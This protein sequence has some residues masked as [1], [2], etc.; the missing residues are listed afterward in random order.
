MQVTD[1]D[2]E[3]LEQIFFGGNGSF[4]D[5]KGER[6][7]FL[8]CFD[9]SL[10]VQACPGSGKT[11]T[12]L[13]K[14]YLLS[15]KMPFED[16]SGVC[17]LTHT[18]VGIDEIKK[19]LG[20]KA[21]RLFQYPNFFGTIQSFVDRF[22]VIPFYIQRN[23]KRPNFIDIDMARNALLSTF[24]PEMSKDHRNDVLWFLRSHEKIQRSLVFRKNEDG[25][26]ALYKGISEKL[27]EIKKPRN[28]AKEYRDWTETEKKRIYTDLETIKKYVLKERGILSYDDAFMYAQQYFELYPQIKKA[29]CKRFSYVFIDEMQ[30]TYFHQDKIIKELF[31][32]DV[33][34]Q[35]IG[36]LNQAIMN[37]NNSESAWTTDNPMKITGSRRVSQPIANILRTVALEGDPELTGW[38]GCEIPAYIIPYSTEKEPDVLERFVE[39]IKKHE[40]DNVNEYERP[41]KAVGW[42][43][44]EKTTLTIGQYFVGFDKG[45]NKKRLRLTN[46]KTAL[47]TIDVS[48]PN[49][50]HNAIISVIIEVLS[51]SGIKNPLSKDGIRSYHKSSFVSFLK[52]D[53]SDLWFE[54]NTKVAGWVKSQSDKN[55]AEIFPEIENY[56]KDSFFPTLDFKL[57]DKGVNFISDKNIDLGIQEK[58]NSENIFQSGTECLDH[59]KVEVNNVHSVKGE[60]HTATLYL[61]TSYQSK[62][63]GEY[64]IDQLCG[65]PYAPKK[66]DT[67]KKQCLKIAHVGMSRP[68]HLL[69]VAL[70]ENLVNDNREN[71]EKNGWCFYPPLEQ[72]H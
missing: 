7:E 36:D 1:N 29:F 8:K 32:E 24:V 40:L 67:Y 18:N 37:D 2:I 52:A 57:N 55:L 12:L 22:L 45:G 10:D 21:D 62:T 13:A 41:I 54:F 5:E 26:F 48:K 64:L 65:S 47:S 35:R 51:L 50:F 11:T 38:D 3:R 4:E 68:T 72:G 60:T 14:L 46:L 63:C 25:S 15:E 28:R 43:G 6:Y 53:H 23:D 20:P 66:K 33:I 34:I 30:D 16:G 56:L 19:R 27:V 9:K 39:L 61:E 58:S 59:I 69:C 71:L 49:E 42:V 44:T 31:G 17:V 70:N